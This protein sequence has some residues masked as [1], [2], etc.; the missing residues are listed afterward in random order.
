MLVY[1]SFGKRQYGKKRVEPHQKRAW[2]FQ[3][4]LKGRIGVLQPTG[5]EPLQANRLWI[6][7]PGHKHGWIGHKNEISQIAVFHFLTAPELISRLIGKKEH[8]EIPL[9]SKN[10]RDITDLALNAKHHWTRPTA[11]MILCYEHALMEL[12]LLA[13]EASRHHA[14]DQLNDRARKRVD[15]AII[16]YTER[17][18]ENPGLSDIARAVGVSVSH[19]KRLF[20]EVLQDSP[21]HILTQIRFQ[22]ALQL[23]SSNDLKLETISENCG[24]SSASSFSRAFSD[25]F[26]C[27][28]ISWRK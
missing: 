20:D 26:G 2:E 8:L 7:P 17:M 25:K 22:R 15:A 6:F 24:F 27:S 19:L 3:A 14:K 23:M 11:G 10:I 28:P 5:P 21:K 4:V 9:S 16:W 13:W 1:L 18:E 12:S